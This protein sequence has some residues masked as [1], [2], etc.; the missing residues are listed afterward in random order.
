MSTDTA[1]GRLD[2]SFASGVEEC[3]AWL[4]LPDGASAERPVPV[5]VMAHGL[6][7]TRRDRLG[8]RRHRWQRC[9]RRRPAAP[10]LTRRERHRRSK[11]L[12]GVEAAE[13][14]EQRARVKNQ[15]ADAR[16]QKG[17]KLEDIFTQIQKGEVA[18]LNLVLKADVQGSLEALTE[19]LRKLER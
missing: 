8:P 3:G 12:A 15:R 6:S 4:Y 13:A 1:D 11:H 9:V 16:V 2:L 5:I 10:L 14:R 19:S 18:T 7:G 17:V